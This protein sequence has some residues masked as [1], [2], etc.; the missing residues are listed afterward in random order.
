MSLK[1]IID[2]A[3]QGRPITRKEAEAILTTGQVPHKLF[4]FAGR[5]RD[6]LLGRE[7]RFYYPL[8]RF[9]N[10]SVTGGGCALGCKHCGGHYLPQS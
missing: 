4:E 1:P 3:R 8:P 7:I 5:E 6:S 2:A 9:P 10:V